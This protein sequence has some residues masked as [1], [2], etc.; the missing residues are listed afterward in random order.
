MSEDNELPP[1]LYHYTT[2]SSLLGIMKDK[3]IR[4]TNIFFLND[5][6]EFKYA[7]DIV[8][9]VIS[10]AFE[11]LPLR[12]RYAL[13]GLFGGETPPD[14]PGKEP[15][16]RKRD[17]LEGIYRVIDDFEWD[18]I[19]VSSFTEEGD[20]LSQWRGYCP[21]G[22]GFSIGLRT[23]ELVNQM[24]QQDFILAKCIYERERQKEIIR[25]IINYAVN[26]LPEAQGSKGMISLIS[27]T[28]RSL[29]PTIPTLKH[30]SFHEEKEWRFISRRR[31][32]SDIEFRPGKSLIIPYRNVPLKISDVLSIIYIGPTP[33]RELAKKSV[34]QLI[35]S[36]GLSCNVEMSKTSYISW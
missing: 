9:E 12:N 28:L 27:D 35:N 1:L 22:N 21:G 5:S 17:F 30:E 25:N 8:K 20:Q 24:K 7:A 6:L 26:R 4:A 36:I 14:D 13:T 29:I 15:E 3:S 18:E 31:A 34:M 10:P 2:Q 32:G 33:H 11:S 16:Y 19:Y 23:S